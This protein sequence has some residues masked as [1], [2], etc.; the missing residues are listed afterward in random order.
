M[1]DQYT[2]FI[3]IASEIPWRGKVSSL[4]YILTSPGW[5]QE[6]NGFSHQNPGF[7]DTMLQKHGCFV[8][9]YFPVDRNSTITVLDKCLSSRNQINLI[10]AGKSMEPEWLTPAEAKATVDRGLMTWDFASDE[11]PDIVLSAV[12]DYLVFETLAALDLIKKSAPE[13]KVRFVNITELSAIGIGNADCNISFYDFNKYFTEDKPV[14]FNFHGYPETMK[15]AL[16]DHQ[17]GNRK[18]SVHG[19]MEI[20]ST[21]T[22]FDMHVRNKTSRYHIASETYQLMAERGVLD[23]E[24]SSKL[25]SEINKK[26][27]DHRVYIYQNGVDMNEIADWKWTRNT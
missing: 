25:I 20:V 3:R 19:Y 12:G 1:A 23:K 6:H 4:N 16:F 13:I 15:Q 11:N 9:V 7:I 17:G 18:F 21:T 24:K 10:V 14:I 27:E 8:H 5:R 26:L 2:K 22:P